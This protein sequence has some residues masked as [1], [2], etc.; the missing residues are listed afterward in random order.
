MVASPKS[1]SAPLFS[2][3]P[4]QYTL[5][6]Y[7]QR[8]E[9]ASDK[10]EFYNGNLIKMPNAK[11][12]H[13]LIT[14]NTTHAIQNALDVAQLEQYFV[15]GDSQKVYIEAENTVVYP[16]ALVICEQPEFYQGLEYLLVNPLVI[17]EV[18]S[19]STVAYDRKDKYSLYKML[20]SLQEYVLI[21]SRKSY[22]ETRYQIQPDVWKSTYYKNLTDMIHL[23][24][25]QISISMAAIYKKVLFPK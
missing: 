14:N 4:R 12:Y 13:N 10:S 24:S 17:I 1:F 23:Q 25:L 9:R 6:A 18:L 15:L 3:L 7:L 5:K 20:P 2:K 19:K 11:F 8:E 16:D 22:M 21:D